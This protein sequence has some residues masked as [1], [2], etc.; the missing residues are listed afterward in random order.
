[1]KI[2]IHF[3]RRG[4]FKPNTIRPMLGRWQNVGSNKTS[5]NHGYDCANEMTPSY[6]KKYPED[7][8]KKVN[9]LIAERLS[10]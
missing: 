1:M 10:K 5:L 4:A 9:K 2:L 8:I 7:H 3:M 6:I